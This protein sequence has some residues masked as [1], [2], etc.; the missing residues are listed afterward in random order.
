VSLAQ[1]VIQTA[2]EFQRVCIIGG[3]DFI[4]PGFLIYPTEITASRVA[5]PRTDPVVRS[6]PNSG[7]LGE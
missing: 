1:P 7:P 5:V 3:H 2:I 6:F 4:A